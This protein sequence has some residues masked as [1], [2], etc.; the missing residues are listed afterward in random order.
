MPSYSLPLTLSYILSQKMF[1]KEYV[2]VWNAFPTS[3]DKYQDHHPFIVI[4]NN[5]ANTTTTM[6]HQNISLA[7]LAC[8]YT[9]LITIPNFVRWI[10][11]FLK[12]Q[13]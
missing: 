11:I 6:L 10:V 1:I 2:E 4:R 12:Q 8:M 7:I 9:I 5:L 13:L 3:I